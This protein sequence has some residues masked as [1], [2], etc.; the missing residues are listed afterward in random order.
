MKQKNAVNNTDDISDSANSRIQSI[1]DKLQHKKP[2]D[3]DIKRVVKTVRR[4]DI[5]Q[6]IA[7]ENIKN[8]RVVMI[9]E[10]CSSKGTSVPM[11]LSARNLKT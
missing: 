9:N 6:N 8:P 7:M 5:S 11:A 3:F 4:C 10:P 2:D 1:S